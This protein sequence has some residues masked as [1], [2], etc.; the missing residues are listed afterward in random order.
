MTK[1]D[2]TNIVNVYYDKICKHYGYSKYQESFPYLSIEDS[3][4]SDAD[5]PNLIGEYCS[6][7]N[8]LIV[9]WKN[10]K[11][12]EELIRTLI[13]EYQHYLQSPTW[14][15][16]YYNMGCDYYTHPYEIIAYTKETEYNL[17]YENETI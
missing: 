15:T 4:Y 13:H 1:K 7:E 8:E 5:E 16:R 9:Y 17:F 10:I 3:P 14:M 12:T 11:S 2:I 6:D